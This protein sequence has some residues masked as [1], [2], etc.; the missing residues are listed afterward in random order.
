MTRLSINEMTTYRW[1]FERDVASYAEAGIRAMGVWRQKLADYGEEEGIELLAERGLSVSNLLWAGGFTGSDG[2]SYGD[3]VE[4]AEEAIR[5]AAALQAGCLV[6]YSGGR[7]G[8]T[9]NHCR[10][11][12]RGALAELVPLAAELDVTLAVEPMHQGC[13]AEW[14]FLTGLDEALELIDALASPHVKLVFDTYHLGQD[15][16]VIA[17]IPTIADRIAIVHLG[18][19]KAVPT[20]EQNRCWL[21]Q[22]IVP[23]AAI[24]DSLL[25]A[26]YQG[27]FDVELIGEDLE[28]AEY[29]ELIAHSMRAFAALVG[30]KGCSAR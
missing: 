6:V 16:G 20:G 24:I 28:A 12:V 21:G 15:E 22:G 7:N 26:G 8:H 1:P 27:D 18:D 30:V 2:R 25:S 9:Y 3:S 13:A 29:S 10:R 14:T 17:Q 19:S 4:D 5:L 11:L 23:L